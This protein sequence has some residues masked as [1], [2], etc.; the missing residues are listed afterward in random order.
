MCSGCLNENLR[1]RKMDRLENEVLEDATPNNI[2]APLLHC[3]QKPT[4]LREFQSMMQH[5]PTMSTH[6]RDDH[7]YGAAQYLANSFGFSLLDTETTDCIDPPLVPP[8]I[9]DMW[10][11]AKFQCQCSSSR[12]NPHNIGVRAFCTSCSFLISYDTS[13]LESTKCRGCNTNAPWQQS[14]LPCI[15]CQLATIVY[16][17]PFQKRLKE[18]IEYWLS[19]DTSSADSSSNSITPCPLYLRNIQGYITSH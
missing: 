7:I 3:L 4:S 5:L 9:N 18:Q 1:H 2:L 13:E 10:R 16:R 19:T 6:K 15:S 17:N 12:Q 14:N 8:R 11:Q